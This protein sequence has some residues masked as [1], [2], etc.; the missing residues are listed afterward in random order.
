MVDRKEDQSTQFRDT[1]SGNF[2]QAAKTATQTQV[3][4]SLADAQTVAQSLGVDLNTGLSQAE[5]KRRLDKYGPNELASA[6]PV[7]KWKKFLEQFKDPLVY[8]LLA[9]TGISLVAWFIERANAVPGA[10]GGEALPFDAI[11]IVLILIVNAVLGYIQESKAEAAVEALSSMTAPQT[12]V[13]RD[14]KIERINTVDVV[15]GDII[16]LGEG[17]S[18]SADG[19][20]FAAASLRIAEASLTGESVP[21]G[22]K[23]DTLAQ[24][25]ALG[26]RANMVFNGTSVTQG[27]GRAIVTSTGMGTQVGKIADHAASHGRRRNPSAKGNELRFQNPRQRGMHHRGRGAGRARAYR[28]LPRRSRCD[29]FATVGRLAGGRGRAGRFGCNSY[30]GA[31]ARRAA[32]GHAQCDRQEA[33]FGGNA[34][35]RVGDLLR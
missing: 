1:S 13:L 3:D 18:V 29:R 32:H 34:R 20:L 12:N 22:K 21:V 4:P 8:L 15:P 9:A 33:A 19:R 11:V 35:I 2:E 26:D 5:A 24:A 28:R 6:P 10:E 14:G 7:P 16:V 23:T 27:T 17:D 31:R 25:K 30:G